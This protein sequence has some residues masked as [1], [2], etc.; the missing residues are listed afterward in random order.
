MGERQWGNRK[1]SI[2][3][4]FAFAFAFALAHSL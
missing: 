1:D 4:A 3:L 2:F